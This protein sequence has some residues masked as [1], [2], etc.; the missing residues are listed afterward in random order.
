[1]LNNDEHWKTGQRLDGT[2]NIKCSKDTENMTINS[3]NTTS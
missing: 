1:M 3:S 2:V